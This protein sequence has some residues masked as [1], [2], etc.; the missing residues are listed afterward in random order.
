MRSEQGATEGEHEQ[1]R[2]L[3]TLGPRPLAEPTGQSAGRGLGGPGVR[4]DP[5]TD[6]EGW[7]RGNY[8]ESFQSPVL[9]QIPVLMLQACNWLR[10]RQCIS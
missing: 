7:T 3:I 2:G 1:L 9:A 8:Q 4:V 10:R 6:D 5:S